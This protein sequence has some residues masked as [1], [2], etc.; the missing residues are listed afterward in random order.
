MDVKDPT[1]SLEEDLKRVVD[2]VPVRP[3]MDRLRAVSTRLDD[4]PPEQ[5]LRPLVD[6]IRTISVEDLPEPY[7]T[8]IKLNDEWRSDDWDKVTAFGLVRMPW[9]QFS[10]M[11]DRVNAIFA[12]LAK[13]CEELN[14]D[15]RDRIGRRAI[16][17]WANEKLK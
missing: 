7:I 16:Q 15:A 8:N 14:E 2:T 13:E 4:L 1:A 9:G 17:K 3:V 11:M 5:K 6:R 12:E 10:E